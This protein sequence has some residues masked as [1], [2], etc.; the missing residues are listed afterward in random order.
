MPDQRRLTALANGVTVDG[1]AYG[2][3]DA[4]LDSRK[5]RQRLAHHQPARGTQ[6][7]GAA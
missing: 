1:V 7:R 4:G 5:G 3:I 6:S 2:P